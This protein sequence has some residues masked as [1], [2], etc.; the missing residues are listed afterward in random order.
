MTQVM[1]GHRVSKS[2]LF[3]PRAVVIAVRV[4]ADEAEVVDDA[5]GL[6]AGDELVGALATMA[7]ACLG[8]G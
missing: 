5:V 2:L 7:L 4:Q 8:A 6:G 3:I 1:Y